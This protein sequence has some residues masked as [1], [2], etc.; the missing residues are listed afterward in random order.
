M[1][2]GPSF[3][4]GLRT[5]TLCV[6]FHFVLLGPAAGSEP[7]RPRLAAVQVRIHIRC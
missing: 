3:H 7:Q 4:A 2:T 6:A 1:A 5:A